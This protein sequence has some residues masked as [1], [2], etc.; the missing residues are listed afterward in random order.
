MR[1]NRPDQEREALALVEAYLGGGGS[2]DAALSALQAL[3]DEIPEEALDYEDAEPF[4]G[5]DLSV[6][7]P[8]QRARFDQLIEALHGPE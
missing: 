7:T 4:L 5:M 6:L 8:Q 1:G 2:M 3:D